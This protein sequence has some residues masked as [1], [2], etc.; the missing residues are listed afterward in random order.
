MTTKILAED[1]AQFCRQEVGLLENIINL[2]MPKKFRIST[3]LKLK[4]AETQAM[5]MRYFLGASISD[6][7]QSSQPSDICTAIIIITQTAKYI[8]Q[9][10]TDRSFRVQLNRI[11]R[12]H[13]KRHMIHT[14]TIHE[15]MGIHELSSL[16]DWDVDF[17]QRQLSEALGLANSNNCSTISYIYNL[18]MAAKARTDYSLHTA[19]HCT[20]SFLLG[21]YKLRLL[22]ASQTALIIA[23]MPEQEGSASYRQLLLSAFNN[24]DS[25]FVS[26]F[27]PV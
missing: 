13:T 14:W 26:Y 1:L 10:R 18:M 27:E 25:H 24:I 2:G 5:A 8:I 16:D 9:S 21:P 17:L 23:H 6:P 11:Q 15:L 22:F 7:L 4:L 3:Y 19:S 12:D 20:P